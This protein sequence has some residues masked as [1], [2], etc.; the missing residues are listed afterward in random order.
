MRYASALACGCSLLSSHAE[1][2]AFALCLLTSCAFASFESFCNLC[3]GL[4]ACRPLEQL[5]VILRPWSP[6]RSLLN[7]RC[8]LRHLQLSLTDARYVPRFML[9]ASSRIILVR[10]QCLIARRL[11]AICAKEVGVEAQ[12]R[13]VL[14]DCAER[15]H[16][17]AFRR[18][19][20]ARL[21]PE[22]GVGLAG[23]LGNDSALGRPEA[24]RP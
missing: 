10:G 12:K 14:F 1:R 22:N 15:R 6:R 11:L 18:V 20:V 24:R 19:K 8:Y 2:D 17:R 7:P 3:G 16:E 9:F 13:S 21:R 23:R 5:N 4:F